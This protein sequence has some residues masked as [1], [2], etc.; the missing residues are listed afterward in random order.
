M[1]RGK[2]AQRLTDTK[3]LFGYLRSVERSSSSATRFPLSEV[4]AVS[5][6]RKY[7]LRK[8]SRRSAW[9]RKAGMPSR[10]LAERFGHPEHRCLARRRAGFLGAGLSAGEDEPLHKRPQLHQV[11]AEPAEVGLEL[12][13]ARVRSAVAS[14]L[15]LNDDHA[16]KLEFPLPSYRQA[17]PESLVHGADRYDRRT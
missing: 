10:W 2:A 13:W 6:D 8:A 14:H 16:L 17:Y 15:G 1:G 11:D 4:S 9:K 3:N 5:S 7:V 12:E